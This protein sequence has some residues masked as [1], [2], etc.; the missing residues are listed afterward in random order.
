MLKTNSKIVKEKIKQ[1]VLDCYIDEERF[2]KEYPLNYSKACDDIMQQFYN[3]MVKCDCRYKAKRI[4]TKELF[5]RWLQGLAIGIGDDIYLHS[6]KEMAA[7]ILEETETE[8]NKYDEIQAEN[9]LANLF[10]REITKNSINFKNL[11]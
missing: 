8:K 2:V 3:E 1:R 9:L 6:A 11:H 4:S 5:V 7:D 10:Y